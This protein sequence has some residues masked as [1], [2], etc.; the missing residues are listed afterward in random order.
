VL[1]AHCTKQLGR[2]TLEVD[3]TAEHGTTLVLVGESGAGKSTIL[4]LLAGLLHPDRGRIQLDDATYFDGRTGLAVPPHRRS[5]GYVFQDY[6]LFPHLSV[7]ENVAFGLR[8][9]GESGPR[10]RARVGEL[11]AQ[12][13]IAE[14]ATRRP[15][16]LSGGQQQRV[17]LARA[18]ILQPRLLLLDEPLAAL[19]AQ[20]RHAVRTELRKTLSALP[21]ITVF[22]TH[23]PFEALVFGDRIAVVE[24]GRVVQ[25]GAC[26]ELLQRPRSRYVATLMGLNFF[27]GRIA[28][29]DPSGLAEVRTDGG[30][31]RIAHETEGPKSDEGEILI[32]VDPSEITLHLT[33]PTGTARNVFSG[34]IVQLVPEP[35][36]GELVRVV[37]DTHPPLVAE[38][39]ANS[40]QTLGL[41]EG[42]AVYASFKATAAR[43]YR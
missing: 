13:G 33:P 24:H 42:V 10:L 21:C 8:A 32:A 41:R 22:V 28:Y 14:L 20:T 3:L 30:T 27:R 19:D 38:I 1:R 12:L 2:F 39:T 18:L 40:V 36:F 9:Q 15:R 11:L 4:N 26:E 16:R 23:S 31:V 34:S 29:R 5:I 17:A 35:P 25:T 37:L 6:A 7:F 43:A